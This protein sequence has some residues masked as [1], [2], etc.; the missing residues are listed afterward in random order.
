MVDRLEN[1]LKGM[2][3]AQ[4]VRQQARETDRVPAMQMRVC[5]HIGDVP[6]FWAIEI[7]VRKY[8]IRERRRLRDEVTRRLRRAHPK[9]AGPFTHKTIEY[10]KKKNR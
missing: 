5:G 10:T 3:A 1:A 4:A 8:D 9:V 7:P 6:V 2:A